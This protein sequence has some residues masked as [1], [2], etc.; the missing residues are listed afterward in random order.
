M[1]EGNINGETAAVSAV[2]ST[3]RQAHTQV[4]EEQHKLSD[5]EEEEDDGQEEEDVENEE[6]RRS[7][8]TR[9]ATSRGASVS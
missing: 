2:I 1:Q 9:G 8:T 3:T 5:T 6:E 4:A 7:R